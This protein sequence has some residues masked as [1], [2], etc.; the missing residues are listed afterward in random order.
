MIFTMKPLEQM[1][2]EEKRAELKRR[3]NYLSKQ[4]MINDKREDPKFVEFRIMM[5]KRIAVKYDLQFPSLL[6]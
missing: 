3:L 2:L 1:T 5:G 6:S 4:K